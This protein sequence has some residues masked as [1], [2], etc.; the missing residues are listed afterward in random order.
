MFRDDLGN[1][2]GL[3]RLLQVAPDP[4]ALG[5]LEDRVDRG[6]L[7]LQRPVVEIRRVVQVAGHAVVAELDVQHPLGDD[8]PRAASGGAPILQGVL[9]GEE[10][11]GRRA[12]V[13][14]VDELARPT[15]PAEARLL[16]WG[17]KLAG[18]A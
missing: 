5:P 13:A 2:M 1:G 14:L 11:P 8:P 12:V 10:H 4:G 9:D 15:T 3:R 7:V 17:R 6:V 18:L 16:T